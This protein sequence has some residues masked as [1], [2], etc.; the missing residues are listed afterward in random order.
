MV[1]IRTNTVLVVAK[2]L[3]AETDVPL[4]LL[5]KI[6]E[7]AALAVVVDRAVQRWGR[8]KCVALGEV[9]MTERRKG[10]LVHLKGVDPRL[11]EHDL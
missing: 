4:A 8:V 1:K 3:A 5:E 10:L 2:L 11:V 7:P 6:G 9:V